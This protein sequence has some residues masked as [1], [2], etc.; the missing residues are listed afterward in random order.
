MSGPQLF[1]GVDPGKSGALVALDAGGAWVSSMP[2]PVAGTGSSARVQAWAV[3]DWLRSLA[4][5]NKTA[6]ALSNVT[7][8]IEKVHSMPAQGMVSTFSFGHATGAVYGA[9]SA[10]GVRIL[11]VSPR[12]WQVYGLRGKPKGTRVQLKATVVQVCYERWPE[13][14]EALT[15]RGGKIRRESGTA[16]AALIALWG[17][18]QHQKVVHSTETT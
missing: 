15:Q 4:P 1:V 10:A 18:G 12:D 8:V 14:R 3:C 2:M 13:S 5:E 9:L 6:W 7:A 16:D 17:L 11:E